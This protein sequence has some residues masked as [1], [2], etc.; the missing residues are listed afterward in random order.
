MILL[1]EIDG[2]I[3][4]FTSTKYE[5]IGDSL[6]KKAGTFISSLKNVLPEPVIAS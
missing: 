6:N 1:I 3:M 4:V 2:S 5:G